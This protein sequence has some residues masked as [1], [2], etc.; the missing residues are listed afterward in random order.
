[1]GDYL[2]LPEHFVNYAD[3]VALLDFC[4]GRRSDDCRRPIEVHR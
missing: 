1:M 4:N 2:E 3:S